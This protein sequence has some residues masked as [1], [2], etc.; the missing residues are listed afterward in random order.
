MKGKI[1]TSSLIALAIAIAGFSGI[2]AKSVSAATSA[3]EQP[4]CKTVTYS[5]WGNCISGIK[6]RTVIDK[7]PINCTM[8]AFQKE[9]RS[10]ICGKVLGVKI[11]KPGSLLRSPDG[12]IYE[13]LAGQKLKVVHNLKELKA[14]GNRQIDNV[15]DALIA[16][17]KQ[18]YGVVLGVKK[19]AEGTLL[20][21]PNFKVYVIQNGKKHYLSGPSELEKYQ[22]KEILNVSAQTIADYDNI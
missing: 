15:S 5:A 16:Q 2:G 22:G 19:Y 10:E 12:K 8:T 3:V 21:G 6:A 7:Y 4:L 17:Y 11:Y 1:L 14:Y 20:R 9:S 18:S 13:V